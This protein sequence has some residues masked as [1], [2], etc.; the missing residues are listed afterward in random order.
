MVYL[1]C[2]FAVEVHRKD[3]VSW[4]RPQSVKYCAL[5][6]TLITVNVSRGSLPNFDL[7]RAY[8]KASCYYF[9][10][11]CQGD[12]ERCRGPKTSFLCISS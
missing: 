11:A 6:N 1:V 5:N 10:T 8:S 2:T 4:I 12:Q 3:T 7:V 9:L